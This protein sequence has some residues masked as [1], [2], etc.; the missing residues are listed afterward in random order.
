M[1]KHGLKECPFSALVT[2]II[3]NLHIDGWNTTA[4]KALSKMLGIPPILLGSLAGIFCS[5][6]NVEDRLKVSVSPDVNDSFQKKSEHPIHVLCQ[7][8][9]IELLISRFFCEA[10]RTDLI[11]KR[12][13]GKKSSVHV[14]SRSALGEAPDRA[15]PA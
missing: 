6:V 4:R 1:L 11:L 14:G 15:S 2:L 13:G 12:A 3:I 7:D 9:Q 5:I 8:D 10:F